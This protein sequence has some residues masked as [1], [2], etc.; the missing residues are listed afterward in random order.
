VEVEDETTPTASSE[1]SDDQQAGLIGS[2]GLISRF[3]N[4][5]TPKLNR[6]QSQ[7]PTKK[8]L[9]ITNSLPVNG[10]NSKKDLN[11]PIE[12][13]KRKIDELNQKIDRLER[14]IGERDQ[15]IE[16]F[17]SLRRRL[18]KISLHFCRKLRNISN[19]RLI[20]E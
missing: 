20:N 19:H 11:D 17:V 15:I 4:N 9:T 8:P 3:E 16:K 10:M 6:S 14:D 12:D 18:I 5:S 2:R 13:T 7:E 1:G